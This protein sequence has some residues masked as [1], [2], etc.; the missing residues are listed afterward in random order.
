VAALQRIELPFSFALGAQQKIHHRQFG[1]V[2]DLTG[3]MSS[4]EVRD[5]AIHPTRTQSQSTPKP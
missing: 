3:K 1:V 4:N 5:T 2:S